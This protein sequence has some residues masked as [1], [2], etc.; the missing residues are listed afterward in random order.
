M[1][2]KRR[3]DSKDWALGVWIAGFYVQIWKMLSQPP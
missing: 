1:I 3:T 2:F